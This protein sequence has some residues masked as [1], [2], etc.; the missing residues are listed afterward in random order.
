MKFRALIVDD[1]VNARQALNNLLKMYCQ[2]IEVVAEAHGVK[3]GCT[4]L[5]ELKPDLVFLDI[6]LSDGTG[7]DLLKKTTGQNFRVIFVTA[8]DQYALNAIRL[9]AVDYLLKPINPT[10]LVQAVV[11]AIN[12]LEHDDAF[13]TKIKVLEDHIAPSG[14]QI[15]RIILNTSNSMH[16]VDI[17]NIIRCESDENYTYF[18]TNDDQSILVSKTLKEFD[19]LLTPNGFCRVHQSHLV[20]MYQ[21]SSYEKGPGGMIIMKNKDK[22]PVSG[23][24]KD[25]FLKSLELLT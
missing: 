24:R 17:N 25:Y 18:I 14:G 23:R 5:I 22:V 13:K 3:D 10:E 1:E 12:L 19:E 16:V 11:K 21:V 6:R 15:K 7:F 2:D 20:N 8:Y 9:S 4:K